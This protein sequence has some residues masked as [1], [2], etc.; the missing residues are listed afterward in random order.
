MGAVVAFGVGASDEVGVGAGDGSEE[1]YVVAFGVGDAD[2]VG[3][4]A[5]DG[6]YFEMPWK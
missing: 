6:L 5:G 2:E 1:G 4:G 3:V